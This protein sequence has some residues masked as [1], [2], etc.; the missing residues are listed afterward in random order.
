MITYYNDLRKEL[1]TESTHD[2]LQMPHGC[3]MATMIAIDRA[4]L[5]GVYPIRRQLKESFG[6]LQLSSPHST[7]LPHNTSVYWAGLNEERSSCFAWCSRNRWV[8]LRC[9]LRWSGS[10]GIERYHC[11][12]WWSP[13]KKGGQCIPLD[14]QMA[15][16]QRR[17]PWL[18]KG[19]AHC[20]QV[21]STS[22]YPRW[23]K[24]KT[25]WIRTTGCCWS[26]PGVCYIFSMWY[27]S[28]KNLSKRFRDNSKTSQRMVAVR[29]SKTVW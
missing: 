1:Y 5:E 7:L 25:R 20:K 16:A 27:L 28:H 13:Y 12:L 18:G 22:K 29:P 19:E 8:S 9:A 21:H 3:C 10:V 26:G 2:H 6:H 15:V 14:L 4:F 11:R 24:L 17:F 23:A